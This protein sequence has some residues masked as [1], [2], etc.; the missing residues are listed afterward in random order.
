MFPCRLKYAACPGCAEVPS[1]AAMR[2][3]GEPLRA[4]FGDA[5][6]VG[7]K[8]K[9]AVTSTPTRG[10]SQVSNSSWT[11]CHSKF[12]PGCAQCR[13]RAFGKKWIDVY[14][15][16]LH[17]GDVARKVVWLQERKCEPGSVWGLGCTV[18]AHLRWRLSKSTAD[19]DQPL[20]LGGLCCDTRWARLEVRAFSQMQAAAFL[21]HSQ[22]NLHKVAMHLY[23]RPQRP[24]EGIIGDE[25]TTAA[26]SLLKGA[27]PPPE[28]W[29]R[30]WRFVQCPTSFRGAQA[31][32][33][34]EA[35]LAHLRTGK[36]QQAT[37]RKAICKSIGC[38]AEVVRARTRSV[39]LAAHSVTI[40][41]DDRG[42]Y[43]VIRFRCDA[44]AKRTR[45][46]GGSSPKSYV[47]YHDGILGVHCTA[48]TSDNTIA[49]LD[50]DYS[51]RMRDSVV[52]SMEDVFHRDGEVDE[53]SVNVVMA[54][55][56]T[57]IADGA[58]S[59]QKCGALLRAS[60]C[61][62]IAMI[63]RDPVHALR[64]S[65]S[66][67]LKRHGDFR[68]FWD[69]VF[70][71]KHALVPDIQNSDAWARRLILA[72]QH[73]LE[74][75]GQQGGGLTCALRHLSFAKQ[76]F[77]S[78]TGP[79]RK[80]CCLLSAIVILLVTV[81]ADR[82]LKNAQR[83]RAQTLIDDMTPARIMT[84]G[85]FADYMAECSSF[86]RQ[87][88]KTDHD[89]ALSYGQKHRFLKRL[90]VLFRDGYVLADMASA[91]EAGEARPAD[92]TCTAIVV[93]QA[94]A[95]G[96]LVYDDRTITLWPAGARSAAE[97]AGA[98]MVDI[99]DAAMERVEAEMPDTD[100]VC[101]FAVFDLQAWQ[102]IRRSR[103]NPRKRA[104]VEDTLRVQC[105]R[106]RSDWHARWRQWWTWMGQ[107]ARFAR[108]QRS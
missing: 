50:D 49:E 78:A 28:H 37:T 35:F 7:R 81:A 20:R 48:A 76:R 77:D 5:G 30:V 92:E 74:V 107:R 53:T 64:T 72:Q 2:T 58:S 42:A 56:H 100:L 82:R 38:I 69:D 90:K 108:S 41:L 24:L 22:T 86:F 23:L 94:M 43:R 55:V 3:P 104:T 75:A 26:L 98:Q 54:K 79:A 84:A 8:G 57:Y 46:T 9:G 83:S 87:Y 25:E 59:V 67:P 10:L 27:V 13:F 19:D 101:S 17:R 34:T 93:S 39:L 95:F 88:E 105:A 62:N 11:V 12:E 103:Q 31:I 32:I 44:A 66:E 40:A 18:C 85:L 33:G 45:E 80:F 73:V 96:T 63:L 14:G 15:T 6:A 16:T 51:E 1:R 52:S 61:R 36:D 70:D 102:R 29:L 4:L 65:T 106:A 99:V 47:S 89:I 91:V 21:Q 97:A 71:Q 68:S 60:R